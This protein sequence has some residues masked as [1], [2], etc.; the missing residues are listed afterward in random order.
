[1]RHLILAAAPFLAACAASADGIAVSK[2]PGFDAEVV[3]T[4]PQANGAGQ[5][6]VRQFRIVLREAGKGEVFRDIF[7]IY[8]P[9]HT[10]VYWEPLEVKD[11]ARRV[12]YVD[13]FPGDA[14]HV[15]LGPDRIGSFMMAGDLG[16]YIRSSNLR[17]NSIAEAEN[18]VLQAIQRS[19]AEALDFHHA[20]RIVGLGAVGMD[21]VVQPGNAFIPPAKLLSA[22][23]ANGRWLLTLES[24][25][26]REIADVTLDDDYRVV[27][28]RRTFTKPPIVSKLP[29]FDAEARRTFPQRSGAAEAVVRQFRIALP[30]ASKREVV[31]DVVLIYEP[32]GGTYWWTTLAV[33]DATRRAEIARNYPGDAVRIGVAPEAIASFEADGSFLVLR[34]S[35][36]RTATI[37]AAETAVLQTIERS[38]ELVLEMGFTFRA[39]ELDVI[40]PAKLLSVGHSDGHWLLTLST[41]NGGFADVTVDDDYHVLNVRRYR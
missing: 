22:G 3:R 35:V 21:F 7:F 37:D 39:V 9:A 18:V 5:A 36:Q 19:P 10:T 24:P 34:I 27:D 15:V 26:G 23:R 28:V 11:G 2:V 17:A 6:V 4:F 13:S 31:R 16:V 20:L 29:G 25:K 12:D 1:M 32:R 40:G 8:E 30:D 41:A 14:T 33:K 38:P